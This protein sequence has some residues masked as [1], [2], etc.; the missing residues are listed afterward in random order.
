MPLTCRYIRWTW[1]YVGWRRWSLALGLALWI[2]PRDHNDKPLESL[3]FIAS[4][5][6]QGGSALRAALWLEA[7]LARARQLISWPPI[8]QF[9]NVRHAVVAVTA[10]LFSPPIIQLPA[11]ASRPP[12]ASQAIACAEPGHNDHSLGDWCLR[13][14]LEDYSR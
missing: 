5:L 7:P 4:Y 3:R 11:A 10:L 2:G 13:E 6:D 14:G 8:D 12:V 9:R 1:L